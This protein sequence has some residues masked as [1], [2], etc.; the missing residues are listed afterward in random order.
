MALTLDTKPSAL[1]LVYGSGSP[2]SFEVYLRLRPSRLQM[3]DTKKEKS[4][5]SAPSAGLE[6]LKVAATLSSIPPKARADQSLNITL[7]DGAGK[8]VLGATIQVDVEMASMDMGISHPAVAET[9]GGRYA[10][11]VAFA[12]RGPW[13]V[14]LHI[15][16]P[17][18][19][20]A[21]VKTLDYQVAP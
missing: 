10:G 15:A 5:P 11:S 1:D 12:M 17:G 18:G 4:A 13:R 9:G 14:T 7:T 20:P 19:G 3:A 2:V 6:A 16:P 21:L 8:P